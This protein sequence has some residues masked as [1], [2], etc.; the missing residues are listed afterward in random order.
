MKFKYTPSWDLSPRQALRIQNKL[1]SKINLRK[2]SSKLKLVAGVDVAFQKTRAIGVLVVLNYPEFKPIETVRKVGRIFFPYIPGLLTFREGPVLEKCFDALKNKPDVIIFDGQ[3]I[4]HPR[5]MGLATHLGILLDR[6]TI[7]CA[8]N[9]LF[10][11][12]TEPGWK[13]GSFSYLLD[14]QGS[15]I[16][17]VL[18]TRDKIKPV[19]ISPGHRIDIS[20]SMEVV[21]QCT[22]KY[23]IP[24]PIRLAHHLA[25]SY[26]RLN[27]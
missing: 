10:G 5:N 11:D 6:P 24:E 7:G 25:G 12:Y 14:K 4:A 26:L 13:R 15:R 19:Y 27:E 16:G 2:L 3:G 18:R 23:R 1:K 22:G 9:H 8:K 17:V 21:L 20:S